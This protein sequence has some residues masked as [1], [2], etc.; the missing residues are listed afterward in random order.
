MPT[1]VEQKVPT[2]VEQRVPTPV[3]QKVP[4]P[5]EQRVPTNLTNKTYSNTSIQH[6]T[7]LKLPETGTN[8]GSTLSIIGFIELLLLV[9]ISLSIRKAK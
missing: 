4:T 9:G 1:P 2:P 8:N 6:S 5:V 3:E 7:I